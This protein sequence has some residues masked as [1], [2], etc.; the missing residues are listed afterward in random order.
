[1][2][3]SPHGWDVWSSGIKAFMAEKGIQTNWISTSEEAD[4]S[5]YL[6]HLGIKTA[7]VDPKRMFMNIS[8]AQIRENSFRY[9]EY[10]PTEVK[11]F[12]V[13]TVA[14][15]GDEQVASYAGQ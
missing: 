14:I 15:L 9:W 13:L 12:F 4:A 10:I 8:G 1:M 5:Q 2:E 3:P 11:P 7:L 6:E